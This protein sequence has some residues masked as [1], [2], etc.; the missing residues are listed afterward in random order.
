MSDHGFNVEDAI[1]YGVERAIILKNLRFWLAKNAA[2]DKH[3]YNGYY[4]TYNSAKAFA[5]LFPYW[6]SNKIQ[7]LLKSMEG[8]GLILSGNFNE[9]AYDRTKWYSMP[10]FRA[11]KEI[12]QAA[13]SIQPKGSDHSADSLNGV[14][15]EAEPIPDINTDNK[16][17]IKHNALCEPSARDEDSSEEAFKVFWEA[18]MVKVKRKDALDKFRAIV[19]REKLNPSEFAAMLAEDVRKRLAAGV[20][21][22]DRL[23]PMTYLNGRRWEDEVV[24]GQTERATSNRNGRPAPRHHT[25][26]DPNIAEKL[27]LGP[28]DMNVPL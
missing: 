8:E 18:G 6:S 7:K 25:L 26:S 19:K 21:G 13:D 17:D 22:F 11:G 9:R 10:E 15:Q 5:E 20:F 24:S 16:P 14:S 3:C 23:H 4:W 28:D 2:N 27:G 1:K 12:S